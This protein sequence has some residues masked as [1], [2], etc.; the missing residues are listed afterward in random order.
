MGHESRIE[1]W[2][3]LTTVLLVSFRL[4]CF[5]REQAMKTA[6]RENRWGA[7]FGTRAE[8]AASQNRPSS[9]R[10]GWKQEKLHLWK[11][12]FLL[13]SPSIELLRHHHTAKRFLSLALLLLRVHGKFRNRKLRHRSQEVS[14]DLP[15]PDVV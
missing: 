11:E 15:Q 14:P 8:G 2:L 9:S 7:M 3:P 6:E 1:P 5:C 13:T 12:C 10:W 4:D